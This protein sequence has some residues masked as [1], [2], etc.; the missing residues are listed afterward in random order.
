MARH[1]YDPTK[2]MYRPTDVPN[3]LKCKPKWDDGSWRRANARIKDF[4]GK[5]IIGWKKAHLKAP[6]SGY[7]LVQLKIPANA[8]RY[9][10]ENKKCRASRA[11]VVSIHNCLTGDILLGAAAKSSY[12]P[13]FL[14]E[15]GKV[16]KPTSR[17][18][19]KFKEDCASGI[20]F[21]LTHD[22]A[23]NYCF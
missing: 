4:D 10:P 17:F 22:E 14:Y 8:T 15:V 7:C 12:D 2:L 21:F 9:Q 5:P 3:K 13:N 6:E 23:R 11:V 19:K 20:H 18:S 16:V 1:S